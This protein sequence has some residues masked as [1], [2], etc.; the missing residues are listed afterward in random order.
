L[1][2]C[3]SKPL[4]SFE[5][6]LFVGVSDERIPLVGEETDALARL[7]P[8]AEV[9][10]GDAAN[11]KKI[12]ES[13]SDT[14]I[15]HLACHGQFRA[16]NPLF[17]SLKLADCWLTVR[18]VAALKLNADLAVLS[19]CETGVSRVAPGDELLGLASGFFSAGAASLVL[20]LWNVHDRTTVELMKHFYCEI[21]AG[22]RPAAALRRAQREIMKKR[23]H[24][25]FWSPFFLIGRW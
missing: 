4:R 22:A 23:P 10:T 3:L 14:D 25:F 19:A 16:K 20:S 17:S 13:A 24:P 9:L 7:F 11:F 12:S 2:N 6:A 18:D 8:K 1:Q 5:K 21:R 15:L